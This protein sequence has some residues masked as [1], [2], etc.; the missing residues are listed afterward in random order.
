LDGGV[1]EAVGVAAGVFDDAIDAFAGGVAD[2]GVEETVRCAATT[3]RSLC[4]PVV[5]VTQALPHPVP[6]R[7]TARQPE[8]VAEL[9][10]WVL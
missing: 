10:P 7:A 4:A 8:Q 5:E 2:L 1:A 6:V 9:L 3:A